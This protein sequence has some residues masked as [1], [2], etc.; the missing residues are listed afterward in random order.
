M[1]WN[2]KQNKTIV[3]IKLD[4]INTC[5]CTGIAEINPA[6]LYGCHLYVGGQSQVHDIKNMVYY[7]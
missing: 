1:S 2:L 7:N 5:T 6:D 3:R 4:I